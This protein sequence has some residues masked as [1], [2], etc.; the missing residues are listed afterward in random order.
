MVHLMNSVNNSVVSFKNTFAKNN[1]TVTAGNCYGGG[2]SV[3]YMKLSTNDTVSSVADTYTGNTCLAG[4]Q[5]NAEGG[6]FSVLLNQDSI[7][8][9]VI[10]RSCLIQCNEAHGHYSAIG[11][12]ASV[13]NNG[14]STE[15]ALVDWNNTYRNNTARSG[16]EGSSLGGGLSVCFN[17]RSASSNVSVASSHFSGNTIR[18]EG[19]QE[20]SC[21]G[22]GVGVFF[23]SQVSGISV[24]VTDV[25]AMF[26]S[27]DNSGSSEGK[28]YGGGL[29]VF[30]NENQHDNPSLDAALCAPPSSALSTPKKLSKRNTARF[31]SEL[32]TAISHYALIRILTSLAVAHHPSMRRFKHPSVPFC[33]ALPD[34]MGSHQTNIFHHSQTSRQP[35]PAQHRHTGPSAPLMTMLNSPLAGTEFGCGQTAHNGI[36]FCPILN[37]GHANLTQNEIVP[38]KSR[39]KAF[40]LR[41]FSLLL[42]NQVAAT[43]VDHWFLTAPRSTVGGA[44][45]AH[46]PRSSQM[47]SAILTRMSLGTCWCFFANHSQHITPLSAPRRHLGA[48]Q[49]R[50]VQQQSWQFRRRPRAKQRGSRALLQSQTRFGRTLR[51]RSDSILPLKKPEP[52]SRCMDSASL[53]C[54]ST[55][56]APASPLRSTA[57]RT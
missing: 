2:L 56:T 34:K 10:V 36:S 3:V 20:G 37:R 39:E 48:A 47:Q 45:V 42:W 5:G 6:A 49:L 12:G 14:D 44:L 46:A 19:S 23:N 13:M 38:Q 32:R 40:S 30:F 54:A 55:E 28:S 57:T 25:S 15:F 41:L 35:K 52:A 53:I 29:S 11:G 1:A 31:E 9:T 51:Q 7:N 8:S 27:A 26:N 17:A 21:L 24:Q 43:A 33:S 50:V 16:G 22:G 18:T 4:Q